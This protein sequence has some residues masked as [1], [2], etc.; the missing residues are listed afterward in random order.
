MA[1]VSAE[2]VNLPESSSAFKRGGELRGHGHSMFMSQV[3]HHAKGNAR[4][5]VTPPVG[6]QVGDIPSGWDVR[7]DAERKVSNHG[8][9]VSVD[10]EVGGFDYNPE[11]S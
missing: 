8:L 2:V 6:A 7:A 5:K 4:L 10:L 11:S 3:G 9:M 1:N